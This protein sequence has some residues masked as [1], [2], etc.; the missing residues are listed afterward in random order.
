MLSLWVPHRRKERRKRGHGAENK[1]SVIFHC[2]NTAAAQNRRSCMYHSQVTGHRMEQPWETESQ[3]FLLSLRNS[4]I[5]LSISL[6]SHQAQF[7]IFNFH[8]RSI[9]NILHH[10][11]QVANL[12]SKGHFPDRSP[13]AQLGF[14]RS[15]HDPLLAPNWAEGLLLQLT[16]ANSFFNS[17]REKFCRAGQ[18]A[19][20]YRTADQKLPTQIKMVGKFNTYFQTT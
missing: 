19:R 4:E 18:H 11:Q 15:Q 12:W 10:H 8:S 1:Q 2:Y 5:D 6:P 9:H 13:Y 14:I 20:S 7:T 16:P 3:C 17:R